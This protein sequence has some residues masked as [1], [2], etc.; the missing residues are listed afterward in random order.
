MLF[1]NELV[2][3]WLFGGLA[4]LHIKWKKK[5]LI[6]EKGEIPI[7]FKIIFRACF[8]PSFVRQVLSAVLYAQCLGCKN[9]KRM[10]PPPKKLPKD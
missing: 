8:T 6:F 7:Y 5:F 9:N 3:C 2:E 4:Q 10:V 1:R